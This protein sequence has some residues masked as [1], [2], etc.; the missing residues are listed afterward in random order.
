MRYLA[1]LP[2]KH[3]QVAALL[4]MALVLG[5]C[6]F[7]DR[8]IH[9]MMGSDS[10]PT[11]TAT[12]TPSSQ[13]ES[14]SQPVQSPASQPNSIGHAELDQIIRSYGCLPAREA[15]F[16]YGDYQVGWSIAGDRY[17]GLLSMNGNSGMMWVEFFNIATN[18]PDQVEQTMVLA[19]CPQG[20]VLLGFNPVI[21]NTNTAHTSYAA[22]NLILR[23]ETNGM[24]TV[25]NRDDRGV[26]ALVEIQKISE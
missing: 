13:A 19:S 24:L 1:P 16:V 6:S 15:E 10:P 4:W 23:R 7:V 26:E 2:L 21:P 9:N 3:I 12:H 20:M 17:E 5:G 8:T 14:S 11:P 25:M 18:Q 22:D